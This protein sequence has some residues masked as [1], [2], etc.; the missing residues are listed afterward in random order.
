MKKKQ[1]TKKLSTKVLSARVT[2]DVY[3]AWQEMANIKK[4]SISECLSDAVENKKIDNLFKFGIELKEVKNKQ[5]QFEPSFIITMTGEKSAIWSGLI[6]AMIADE[7]F[8]E[9]IT[10]AADYFKRLQK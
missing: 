5:I 3:D 10:L 8:A 1:L 4:S 9:H 7:T 2:Q 6:R